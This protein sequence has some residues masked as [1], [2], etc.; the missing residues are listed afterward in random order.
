MRRMVGVS[1]LQD[2]V[3]TE[4]RPEREVETVRHIYDLFVT[5]GKTENEITATL[6]GQGL[7]GEYGCRW[8]PQ[9]STR[10]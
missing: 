6:N 1:I 2:L 10:Y 3:T 9:P 5:G 8:T 4:W 7:T